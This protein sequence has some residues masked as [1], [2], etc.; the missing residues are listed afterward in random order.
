MNNEEWF[1]RAKKENV[2]RAVEPYLWF[3]SDRYIGFAVCPFC[4]ANYRADVIEDK[5]LDKCPDCGRDLR[6]GAE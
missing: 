6:K 1:E 3:P 4:G 2:L 5:K